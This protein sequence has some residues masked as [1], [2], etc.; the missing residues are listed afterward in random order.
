[1]EGWLQ[2]LLAKLAEHLSASMSVLAFSLQQKKQ[3][4]EQNKGTR[5]CT[6]EELT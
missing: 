6:S 4:H 5:V 1:M 2:D 3:K